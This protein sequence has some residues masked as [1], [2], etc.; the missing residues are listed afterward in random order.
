MCY[1]IP[2]NL[3]PRRYTEWH[4]SPHE[5]LG[6]INYYAHKR[7]PMERVIAQDTQ[8]IRENYRRKFK[9][10]LETLKRKNNP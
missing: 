6:W 4:D 8:K 10:M 2:E 3:P 1:L 5:R 9:E 7:Y